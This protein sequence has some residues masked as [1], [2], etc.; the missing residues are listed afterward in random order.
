MRSSTLL[1]IMF[2]ALGPTAC[3]SC[4]D[5]PKDTG[6]DASSAAVT[7]DAAAAGSASAGASR[8]QMMRA[9]PGPVGMIAH[10][11]RCEFKNSQSSFDCNGRCQ[12]EYALADSACLKR[13][14]EILEQAG[15]R[16]HLGLES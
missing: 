4:D 14:F 13:L 5:K 8:R 3:G 12:F 16:Q 10:T 9:A 11:A 1:A 15:Q 7:T 2:A 6:T